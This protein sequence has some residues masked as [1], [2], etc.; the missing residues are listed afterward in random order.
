MLPRA[1]RALPLEPGK[2]LTVYYSR[3]GNTRAVAEHIRELAGGDLAEIKAAHAYPEDYRATTDQAKRELEANLRPALA[4][5]VA[6][7]GPYG[8]VFVGFPNWWGTMPMAMF[9]FLERHDFSGKTIVPFCTH[10]G[11][12]LG[13]SIADI[14]ALCPKSTIGQGLA[15]RGGSGGYARGAAAGREIDAWVRGLNLASAG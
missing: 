1:A 13:R 11:S 9:A 3:T 6:D 2:V 4:S 14:R 8:T 7:I 5:D 10:E 12:A 15:L